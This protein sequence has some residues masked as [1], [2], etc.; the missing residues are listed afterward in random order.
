MPSSNRNADPEDTDIGSDSVSEPAPPDDV[1]AYV[2]EG[3]QRQ[4]VEDLERLADYCHELIEYRTRPLEPI[5]AEGTV[6]RR[7]P[8]KEQT[9]EERRTARKE[10]ESMERE[11]LMEL[12]DEELRR[13][14][15][16]QKRKIPCGKD[17]SGCPHGLY[18]YLVFRDS[19]GT[20]TSR[21]A[22]KA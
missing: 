14:G 10:V 3:L 1:A 7:E 11:Q 16:L 12:S 20:V 2:V 21:Y 5:D 8:Q 15:S 19:K 4:S 9:S 18:R 17:C 22:G 13:Y 6:V